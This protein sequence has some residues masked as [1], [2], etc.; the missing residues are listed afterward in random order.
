[1]KCVQVSCECSLPYSPFLWKRVWLRSGATKRRVLSRWIT[2]CEPTSFVVLRCF[3]RTLLGIE[4][5]QPQQS[6]KI[7][8]SRASDGSAG[9]HCAQRTRRERFL[10]FRTRFENHHRNATLTAH[11]RPNERRASTI[12]QESQIAMKDISFGDAR[13][14]EISDSGLV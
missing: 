7:G 4:G 12:H 2:D 13:D 8:G 10:V 3:A 14:D 5:M 6:S 1:M 9:W 11:S